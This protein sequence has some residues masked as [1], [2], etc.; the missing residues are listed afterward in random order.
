MPS[1]PLHV[2]NPPFAPARFRS[3]TY[4]DRQEVHEHHLSIPRQSGLPA[5]FR[6]RSAP[7]AKK[8]LAKQKN[9][10][11][12]RSKRS[13][14]RCIAALQNILEKSVRELGAIRLIDSSAGTSRQLAR[15]PRGILGRF[16]TTIR[17]ASLL[18][19]VLLVNL[20]LH[21]IHSDIHRTSGSLGRH[22]CWTNDTDADVLTRVASHRHHRWLGILDFAT[23]TGHRAV[24]C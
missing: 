23:R 6:S 18:L 14:L 11:F 1:W 15:K 20:R 13:Q 5:R 7:S 16:R 3:R 12:D 22:F 8:S 10:R 2:L 19:R 21:S 9:A 24:V 17:F 4:D